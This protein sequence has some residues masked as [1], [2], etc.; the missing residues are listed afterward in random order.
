MSDPN[1]RRIALAAAVAAFG[2]AGGPARADDGPPL[3][4]MVYFTLQ[5]RTPA[6]ADTLVKACR[7]YLKA[8]DGE[9]SFAVGTRSP[10]ST[11]TV[12]DLDWDV[13]LVIV[14]KTR[15]DHDRYQTHARHKQFITEFEKTWAKVRVFDANLAPPE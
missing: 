10:E 9:V 6:S 3:A 5:E 14:F 13:S 11:R 2:A 8:H 1:L 7:K 12:N 4:H 15:A